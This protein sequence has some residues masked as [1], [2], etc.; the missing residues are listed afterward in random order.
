ML[1][2]K[3][4]K[5]KLKQDEL[6]INESISK[7]TG[8]TKGSSYEVSYLPCGCPKD[9]GQSAADTLGGPRG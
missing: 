5:S 8:G 1:S 9:S 7:I 2:L 3:D 6:L 4:F